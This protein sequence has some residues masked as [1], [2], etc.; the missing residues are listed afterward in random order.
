MQEHLLGERSIKE[1]SKGWLA[2]ST[3]SL[4]HVDDL[5]APAEPNLHPKDLKLFGK[6]IRAR[7]EILLA[8]IVPLN[9]SL[10]AGPS[11]PEI[12]EFVI[13]RD[14]EGVG[15]IADRV[16]LVAVVRVRKIEPLAE[17]Y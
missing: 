4:Q 7:K 9:G 12:L 13:E 3:D 15:V 1:S 11:L 8:A 5:S 17:I 16:A 10:L 14:L 2:C 6:S